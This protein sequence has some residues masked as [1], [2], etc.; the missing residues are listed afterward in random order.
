M[1]PLP[2][3]RRRRVTGLGLGLWC[4]LAGASSLLGKSVDAAPPSAIP[5]RWNN[6]TVGGGGFSPNIVFSP[7]EKGL[8]Y[9]R[10]DIGGLYRYDRRVQRWVPLQ[11]SMSE[12]NYFGVESV[13][14]IRARP[15]WYTPPWACT[16]PG[17]LPLCAPT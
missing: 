6:V 15:T 4:A 17:R 13:A 10:T 16:A 8:A 2:F 3:L 12:G 1:I 5:Y 11:D 14:P 7:V 9:L